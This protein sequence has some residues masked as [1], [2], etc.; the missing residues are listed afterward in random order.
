MRAGQ[1]GRAT[2][3]GFAAGVTRVFE[4]LVFDFG[5]ILDWVLGLMLEGHDIDSFNVG[6]EVERKSLGSR[7]DAWTTLA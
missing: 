2:V 4:V 7:N 1:S 3:C 6:Q 5:G